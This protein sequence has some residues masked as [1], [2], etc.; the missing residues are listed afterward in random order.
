MAN[1]WRPHGGPLGTTALKA[2]PSRRQDHQLTQRLR[3]GPGVAH[4]AP[5]SK[6]AVRPSRP[7]DFMAVRPRGVP[8]AT[9]GG[10]HDALRPHPKTS[11]LPVP[12]AA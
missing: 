1:R 5:P 10:H 4:L 6:A 7:G 8:E 11:W 12:V 3:G 2:A 9:P